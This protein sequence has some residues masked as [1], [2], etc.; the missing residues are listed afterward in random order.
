MKRTLIPLWTKLCLFLIMYS[1]EYVLF[2][3]AAISWSCSLALVEAYLFVKFKA[4]TQVCVNRRQVE[5]TDSLQVDLTVTGRLLVIFLGLLS[6]HLRCTLNFCQYNAA[7]IR[8]QNSKIQNFF[9]LTSQPLIVF[10]SCS[11]GP[12]VL[13]ALIKIKNE[14]DSTLTFRRSCREGQ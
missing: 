3:S 12:M 9:C 4:E 11:C 2:N 13:D 14:M 1:V 6:N 8:L 5:Q 7:N 10:S